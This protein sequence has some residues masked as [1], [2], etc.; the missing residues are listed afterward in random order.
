MLSIDKLNYPVDLNNLYQC[1]IHSSK[2]LKLVFFRKRIFCQ[3]SPKIFGQKSQ[4]T[5]LFKTSNLLFIF[6][7]NDSIKVNNVFTRKE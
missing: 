4:N 6:L 3:K 2:A 7:E 5:C 1:N